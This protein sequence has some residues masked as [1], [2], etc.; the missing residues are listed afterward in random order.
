MVI[1]QESE[2]NDAQTWRLGGEDLGPKGDSAFHGKLPTVAV[3]ELIVYPGGGHRL[4]LTGQLQL[5]QPYALI[6]P[7]MIV[8]DWTVLWQALHSR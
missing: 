5:W 3:P 4:Q 6:A 7:I 2:V 1:V 8:V